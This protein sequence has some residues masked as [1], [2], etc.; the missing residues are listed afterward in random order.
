M[1]WHHPKKYQNLSIND[2]PDVT[3]Q[4]NPTQSGVVQI[5]NRVNMEGLNQREKYLQPSN[6]FQKA[7]GTVKEN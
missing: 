7:A 2:S 1:F 3:K 5:Q 4:S 6:N